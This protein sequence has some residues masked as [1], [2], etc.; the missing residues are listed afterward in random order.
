MMGCGRGAGEGG[1]AG[2]GGTGTGDGV[3]VGL[4]HY[5][6]GVHASGPP[7]TEA[8]AL[9]AVLDR[10]APRDGEAAALTE[11]HTAVSRGREHH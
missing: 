11:V 5:D 1:R 7:Q 2:G 3:L 10:I 6:R 9:H 4:D 8:A